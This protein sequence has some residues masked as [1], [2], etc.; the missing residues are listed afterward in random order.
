MTDDTSVKKAELLNVLIATN[1]PLLVRSDEW[2][3]DELLFRP[4]KPRTELLQ[5]VISKATNT[6]GGSSDLESTTVSSISNSFKLP[7]TD[8]GKFELKT[9]LT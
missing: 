1:C 3:I 8:E 5:W 9:A 7:E 4:G 2:W 6:F